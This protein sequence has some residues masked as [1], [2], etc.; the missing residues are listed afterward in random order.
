METSNIGRT[1]GDITMPSSQRAASPDL[2]QQ[3]FLKIMVEQM[4]NQNPLE[5]QDNSQFFTQIAQ[6]QTLDTMKSISDAI[7]SLAEVSGLANSSSLIGRQVTAS[8]P[9]SPDPET[10]FPRPDKVVT[11]IVDRVTFDKDGSVLEV[12][13]LSIPTSKVTEITDPVEPD[14]PPPLTAADITALIM[15]QLA[16]AGV[17]NNDNAG[18]TAA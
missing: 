15:E 9:Q 1:L 17:L 18:G 3:D 11:G 12:N 6:F 10:G 7:S 8:V 5:P 2:G 14:Q 16:A 4:R 13:G